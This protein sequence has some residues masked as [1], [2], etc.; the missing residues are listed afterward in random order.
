MARFLHQQQLGPE[1]TVL[2]NPSNLNVE[3]LKI[4]KAV[5]TG[6]NFL[7]DLKFVLYGWPSPSQH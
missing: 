7:N 1:R 2:Y 6:P 5:A 3:L 4:I